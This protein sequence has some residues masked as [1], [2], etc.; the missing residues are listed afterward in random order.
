NGDM[1]G[2]I[3]NMVI[4]GNGASTTGIF[5]NSGM[6]FFKISD[7]CFFSCTDYVVETKGALIFHVTDCRVGG[8]MNGFKIRAGDGYFANL[9]TFTNVQFGS[10]GGIATNINGGSQIIFNSCDWENNGTIGNMSTGNIVASGLSALG[11]GVDLTFN[12]CWSEVTYGGYWLNMQGTS[13]VTVFRDTM[14]W[15][16]SATGSAPVGIINNGNKILLTGST[17]LKGFPTDIRTTNN[18]Q[19]RVDGFATVGTHSETTGGTFKT[20][21]ASY[22]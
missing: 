21:N 22:I 3:S 14:V 15:Q 10:L 1:L 17:S 12:N 2:S 8:G 6:A 20:N 9:I 18:G 13:G 7:M 19:T 5:I 4:N 11:E 16:P